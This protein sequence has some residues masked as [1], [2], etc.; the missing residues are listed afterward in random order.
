M[1]HKIKLRELK[2][3]DEEKSLF[4]NSVRKSTWY[5]KKWSFNILAQWQNARL[6]KQAA[7]K[8]AGFHRL[9]WGLLH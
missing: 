6:N 2:A 7:N 5:D 9:I 8:E 4:E 3:G 1:S